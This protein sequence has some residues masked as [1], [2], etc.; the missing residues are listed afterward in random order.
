MKR[1]TIIIVTVGIALTLAIGYKL[2]RG[3]IRFEREIGRAH[4]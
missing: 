2:G 3:G 4:V 1:N